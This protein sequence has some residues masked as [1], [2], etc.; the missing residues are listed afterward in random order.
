VLNPTEHRATVHKD[1]ENYKKTEKNTSTKQPY[2][3]W[4]TFTGKFLAEEFQSYNFF[5]Y[6]V[7]LRHLQRTRTHFYE[8]TYANST[9][10]SMFE[11]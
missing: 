5:N 2:R 7:Q 4:V 1:Q 11:N 9:T 3:L 8:H 6:T 10:M